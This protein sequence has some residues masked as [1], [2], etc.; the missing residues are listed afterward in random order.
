MKRQTSFVVGL[1]LVAATSLQMAGV[2]SAKTSPGPA[3]QIIIKS[4]DTNRGQIIIDSVIAAQDGW[5]VIY[6]DP[7]IRRCAIIGYTPVH[8]GLNTH[9]T[10]DINSD[11]AEL[12]STLWAVLHVDKGI[13][14]LLEL[15][16]P[17]EPVIQD[18]KPVMVAFGTH[19]GPL[20][21]PTPTK[22]PPSKPYAKLQADYR[23]L[24]WCKSD[25]PGELIGTMQVDATGGDGHY[26]YSF[27]GARSTDTFNFQWRACSV[28]VESLHVYSSDGQ[29]IAV[30]V[31]R[32]D[33]PCPRN[34]DDS[35][36]SCTCNCGCGCK[37]HCDCGCFYNCNCDCGCNSSCGCSCSCP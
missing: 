21:E 5:L 10:A 31:W 25:T 20:P 17:D 8:R 18:G 6:T 33:L 32:T 30:P 34:W 28:L 37:C 15:P 13:A 29:H 22:R 1:L 27:I 36:C 4:Q 19:P 11:Q 16:G 26:T 23:I 7:C 9:F 14:G 35:I 24:N 3:N 12:F 2:A